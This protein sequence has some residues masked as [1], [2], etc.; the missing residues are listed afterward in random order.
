MG[1]L[2]VMAADEA[3]VVAAFKVGAALTVRL[4]VL[5]V[6]RTVLLLA[7]KLPATVTLLLAEI[8]A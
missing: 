1:A 2:V 4:V 5:S 6:P 3:N 8:A 7:V